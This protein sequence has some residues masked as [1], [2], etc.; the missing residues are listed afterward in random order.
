MEVSMVLNQDMKSLTPPLASLT[1]YLALVCKGFKDDILE[2]VER[3]SHGTCK[4]ESDK[5]FA[6]RFGLPPLAEQSRIVA[7]VT[8]LRTLCAD[9]RQRL[10]AAQKNQSRLAEAL[11]ESVC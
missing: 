9:L 6:F 7:R 8:K 2:L 4:L 1:P 5:L 11:V 10:A 3:S